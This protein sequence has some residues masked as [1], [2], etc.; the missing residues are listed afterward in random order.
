MI[1]DKILLPENLILQR[2]QGLGQQITND[3][4]GQ[5]FT[6][7][8]VLKGALVFVADLIRS[9]DAHP[10]LDFVQISSYGNKTESSGN[11]DFLRKH[12]TN[13]KGQN[14]LVVDD[15]IDSGLTLYYLNEYILSKKPASLRNCVLL[16]KPDRR[17]KHITID[18][19]GFDIPDEFVVGYG[20]DFAE[21]YRCLRYIATLRMA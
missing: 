1:I 4:C 6:L 14:I 19:I 10:N 2:V 8:C 9:M 12:T 16:N 18:Y 5:S 21:K 11:I 7:I 15:I 3:Y 20:L 13:I 17:K